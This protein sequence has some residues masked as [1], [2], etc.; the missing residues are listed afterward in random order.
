MDPN[1]SPSAPPAAWNSGE[2]SMMGQPPPPSY[3][4]YPQYPGAGQP[5]PGYY[6]GH[7]QGYVPPPQ[8][9]GAPGY[10]QPYP[11]GM[12]PQGAQATVA[13]QPTTVYVTCAPL[14]NPVPDYLGYSIFTMLCC[15]L[16]IG[17]AALVSSISTRDAN[18]QGNAEAA[19][20]SSRRARNLNHT[21]LGIG[22]AII[23]IW[24]VMSV[25]VRNQ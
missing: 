6:P 16:P 12:Y 5:Q 18:N 15:C 3:Q 13:V 14:A 1:K 22:L 17:I 24:I 23:I 20:K 25:V 9:M 4:E 21:G 11:G 7:P 10:G 8:P 19:Q 2:K